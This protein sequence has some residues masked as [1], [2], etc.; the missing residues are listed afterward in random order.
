MWAG[1]GLGLGR[2]GKGRGGEGYENKMFPKQ[3]VEQPV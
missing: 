1:L 2:G 3:F